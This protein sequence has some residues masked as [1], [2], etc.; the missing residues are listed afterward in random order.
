MKHA[1]PQILLI[2]VALFLFLGGCTQLLCSDYDAPVC[3]SDGRMYRNSCYA[4]VAGATIVPDGMCAASSCKENDNG[5][6]IFD[7]ATATYKGKAYTDACSGASSVTEYYCTTS[8][9][10]SETLPCPQGYHCNGGACVI[11]RCFDTDDGITVD[12]NGSVIKGE[13]IYNDV[14][15]DT[16]TITEY[17]CQD[18]SPA[19]KDVGCGAGYECSDGRCIEK[20]TSTAGTAQYNTSRKDT[21]T[22][23]A[24]SKADY[25]LDAERVVD[26]FCIDGVIANKITYCPAGYSCRD[27]ACALPQCTDSDDGKDIH[28]IGKVVKGRSE[29]TDTCY[30]LNKVNEYFCLGDEVQSVRID[31]P[32]KFTCLNGQCVPITSSVCTDD[33]GAVDMYKRGTVVYNGISYPDDCIGSAT[34]RDYYC[35]SGGELAHTF[36][37]CLVGYYCN[38]GAC[39]KAQDCYDSDDGLDIH[40]KGY[41]RGG[42]G[43]VYQDRCYTA[44]SVLE[45][46]C[47]RD[48]VISVAV[49]CGFGHFCEDGACN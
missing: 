42:D 15:K 30:D 4:Q 11:S 7:V 22:K 1:A 37:K 9:M 40:H 44:S 35:T 36:S 18:N 45:H 27:G 12:I 48:S 13:T 39:I 47:T 23:G 14:C 16:S 5:K 6:D 28:K 29:Y 26:Y 25:C 21:T 20:C 34:V 2:L 24:V 46:Y 49:D 31:C 8:G 43:Q 3:G 32:L 33:E 38:N 19:S 10:Q 17:Y 41:V